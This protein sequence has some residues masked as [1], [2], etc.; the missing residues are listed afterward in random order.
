MKITF[1]VS[2]AGLAGGVRVIAT[3]AR[4]LAERGHEVTI[5]SRPAAAP[6][7]KRQIRSLVQNRRLAR[8]AA[9]SSLFAP[10]GPRHRIIDSVRPIVD[11]DVPDGDV[12][13]ATLWETADWVQALSPSKGR[14]AYLL[15]DYEMFETAPH[16]R[17]A[18]SYTYDFLRIAV[19]DYVRDE[20]RTHHGV[21]D[22][23]VVPNAVDIA[24]FDAPPRDRNARLTLGFLYQTRV[25]KNV[26][27]AL[28]VAAAAMAARPDLRILAFGAIPPEA[29]HPLPPGIEYRLCP[30]EAE[31]P[32]LYAACDGWLFTSS[33]E[34]FGLPLLEAMACRTPVLATPAGAAPQL[35]REGVNGWLIAP[36]V[37]AFLSRI[38]ALR[39]M[40]PG[41]WRAMSEAAH[42]TARLWTWEDAATRFEALIEA[43]RRPARRPSAAVHTLPGIEKIGIAARAED[44]R[45]KRFAPAR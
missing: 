21:E 8:P 16:D 1:I 43:D 22:I 26:D 13:I 7:W 32:G 6:S 24:H 42:D 19:S 14:K 35:I 40:P 25:S 31:I 33:A 2:F 38:E 10:L 23:H 41:A 29:A 36:E 39:D 30:P 45:N 5:V 37:S 4:I 12:V 34:G 27:L 17:V 44:P 20:I 9:P 28:G 15:Q 18:R 11:A 3:Y